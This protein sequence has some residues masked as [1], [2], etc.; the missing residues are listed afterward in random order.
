ME[1][2]QVVDMCEVGSSEANAAFSVYFLTL[3]FPGG[4][5]L[6]TLSTPGKT[7]QAF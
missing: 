4:M 5:T 1:T 7:A 2:K 6:R 3:C